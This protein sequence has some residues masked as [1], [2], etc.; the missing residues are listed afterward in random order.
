MPMYTFKC[1]KCG[2]VFEDIMPINTQ[3]KD[4]K[5]PKCGAPV[6]KVLQTT[7]LKFKGSGFYINDYKGK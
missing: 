6:E 1:T 3:T 4:I 2:H 5:C 7:G